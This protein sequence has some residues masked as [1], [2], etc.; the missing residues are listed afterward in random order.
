[1]PRTTGTKRL[2]RLGGAGW[3]RSAELRGRGCAT[4]L[5]EGAP[6]RPRCAAARFPA[7]NPP[8]PARLRPAPRPPVPA[9]RERPGCFLG[10]HSRAHQASEATSPRPGGPGR[11]P[12][13]GGTLA[14]LWSSASGEVGS[15]AAGSRRPVKRA[16]LKF[17]LMQLNIYVKHPGWLGKARSVS[18][19]TSSHSSPKIASSAPSSTRL[20]CHNLRVFNS[21][22]ISFGA[23]F[24]PF[25]S[26]PTPRKHRHPTSRAGWVATRFA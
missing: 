8:R 1:M 25:S 20:A 14:S 3:R 5:C 11:L 2:F 6:G 12:A 9:Q 23:S 7:G 22:L 26:P 18:R 4:K 17:L 24:H 15:E 19:A 13:V 16:L 10:S 21:F